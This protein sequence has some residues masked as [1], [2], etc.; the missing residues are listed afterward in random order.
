MCENLTTLVFVPKIALM[1]IK[2]AL[3]EV[4]VAYCREHSSSQI[5]L[6]ATSLSAHQ[7]AINVGTRNDCT[8][9]AEKMGTTSSFTLG[10][11]RLT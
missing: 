8:G 3:I 2:V 4:A 5:C 11:V 10:L 7:I 1:M 9:F 6:L